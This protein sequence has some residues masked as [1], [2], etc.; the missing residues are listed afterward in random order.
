MAERRRF[1]H[2]TVT[3]AGSAHQAATVKS[4][5]MRFA[6]Q[7]AFLHS[8]RY[9]PDRAAISYWEEADE[10]LDAAALALRVWDE[11]RDSAGLP[12]WEVVGLEVL[13][14][15]TFSSRAKATPMTGIGVHRPEPVPF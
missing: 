14:R 10:M 1:W 7:H 15:D 6:E 3:V 9:S 8:L 2:V 11:H 4:A 12:R 5:L 13:E